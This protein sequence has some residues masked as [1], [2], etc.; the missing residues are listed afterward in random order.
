VPVSAIRPAFVQPCSPLDAACPP[1]GRDWIHEPSWDGYRIIVVKNGGDVRLYSKNAMELGKRLPRLIDWFA[2][3]GIV[4]KRW[5]KPYVSGPS[6]FWVKVKCP[7]WRRENKDRVRL[8]EDARVGPDAA[9]TSK[10]A[11]KGAAERG[12]DA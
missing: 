3:D 4:S 5:D 6:R 9:R 2:N 1:R 8:F 11:E 12:H 10:C 7:G